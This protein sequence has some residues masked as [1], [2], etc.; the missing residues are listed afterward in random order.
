MNEG[1]QVLS[2]YFLILDMSASEISCQQMYAGSVAYFG[3]LLDFRWKLAHFSICL[4][5]TAATAHW[6]RLKALWLTCV[7][8]VWW[9][10][11]LGCRVHL[12]FF[13]E[14]C[15]GLLVTRICFSWYVTCMPGPRLWW[16][17]L[18]CGLSS[19][20]GREPV[21]FQNFSF[22]MVPLCEVY[23]LR[24][25]SDLNIVHDEEAGFCWVSLMKNTVWVSYSW[26]STCRARWRI[27][28]PMV[29]KSFQI[30]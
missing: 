6:W 2:S 8:A 5:G 12:W 4:R 15:F 25:P 17:T 18:T 22:D 9:F 10:Q 3:V 28:P 14:F 11:C 1:K 26:F 16:R 20:W 13:L 27:L 19:W 24:L 21:G 7:F 30:W 29:F 23:D